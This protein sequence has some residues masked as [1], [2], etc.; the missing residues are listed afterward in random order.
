[1]AQNNS[2]HNSIFVCNH[3]RLMLIGSHVR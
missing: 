2:I 1:V 3:K